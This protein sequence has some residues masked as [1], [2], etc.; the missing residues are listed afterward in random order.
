MDKSCNCPICNHSN[1]ACERVI[2]K[3]IEIS[4]PVSASPI[5]KVGK[6]KRECC[7]PQICHVRGCEFVIKQIICV[8]I[9]ICYDV[10]VDIG[11][12]YTDCV[13][14]CDPDCDCTN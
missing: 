7:K 5:V 4:T 1:C 3:D 12:S 8:E 2:N 9:P 6:I 10:D 11:D 14:D 13:P